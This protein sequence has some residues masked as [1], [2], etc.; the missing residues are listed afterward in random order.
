MW[1]SKKYDDDW[2]DWCVFVDEGSD[3]INTIKS[4][5]YALHPS[6]PDPVRLVVNKASKF[7]LFSSGWGGFSI[8][9]RINYE[10]GSLFSTSYSLRL[11]RSWPIKKAPTEFPDIDAKIVYE[12]LFHQ[13]FRWRKLETLIK[14]SNLTKDS[15][16]QRL[17]YLE[18]EELVRKASFLSID[19]QEMWGATAI[20]GL[21]PKLA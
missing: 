9:I 17:G 3:V 11:D 2:Y 15:V 19:G 20:V 7:A 12:L 14:N 18:R 8:K 16:L 1:I 5:E 4:I 13:K 10:N 6:F 21:S